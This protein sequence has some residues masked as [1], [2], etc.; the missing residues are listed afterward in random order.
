MGRMGLHGPLPPTKR[1]SDAKIK[2]WLK[3]RWRSSQWGLVDCD[4]CPART[5]C[6]PCDACGRWEQLIADFRK[7]AQRKERTL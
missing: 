7:K 6:E 5:G 2:G 1:S 3:S 4:R